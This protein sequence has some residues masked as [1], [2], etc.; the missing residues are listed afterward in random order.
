MPKPKLIGPYDLG[1]SLGTGT[2][3]KVRVGT[4]TETGKQFAIKIMD[5]ELVKEEQAEEQIRRE[6]SLFKDL[7]H[8]FVV[9][10]HEVIQTET[11]MYIVLDLVSGGDLQTK[12]QEQVK[13]DESVGRRYFQQLIAGVRYCHGKNIAHRDLKPENLLLDERDNIKISDFGLANLQQ[14][15]QAQQQIASGIAPS[16]MQTVCGTPNYIAP[17]VLKE[18]GY[19]GTVADVWS[20]GVILVYLLSG[21]LPFEDANLS[22]LY[23]KIERGDFSMPRF[24]SPELKF[25]VARML[26]VDP[27]KRITVNE[28]INDPWFS[29]DLDRGIFAL[30]DNQGGVAA[31]P[32]P[33]TKAVTAA[34]TGAP[35]PQDGFATIFNML[36]A[37]FGDLVSQGKGSMIHDT[38]RRTMLFS[39]N[40]EAARNRLLTVLGALRCNPKTPSPNELKGFSNQP[41]GLMTWTLS[42]QPTISPRLTVLQLK[43][44][45]KGDE[46]DFLA[47]AKQ[48][49]A[50]V[51]SD[52][53]STATL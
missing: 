41:K 29:V 15:A 48:I 5:K 26:T 19:L 25:L 4:H 17:E 38:R 42:I 18:E 11:H 9:K 34:P 43:L 47:I 35:G 37:N 52:L 3:S 7:S 14:Q 53:A 39:G 10:M 27:K 16:M 23:T 31:A 1:S 51:G 50:Q 2:F 21:A 20:C 40:E 49:I 28:I 30:G 24:F 36:S 13:L 12:L 8:P 22:V 33:I 46:A 45:N 44:G 32:V 6:I